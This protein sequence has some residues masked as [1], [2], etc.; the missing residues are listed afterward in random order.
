ML[1]KN[2]YDQKQAGR[3]WHEHLKKG[4]KNIEFE[5]SDF[6][7]C[8]FYRGATIFFVYVDDGVFVSLDDGEINKAITELKKLD[9]KLEDQGDLSDYVGINFRKVEDGRIQMAQPHLIDQILEECGIDER[10]VGKKV[11]ASSTRILQRITKGVLRTI[12]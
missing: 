5:Q 8:V 4:L 9:F 2:L 1:I 7:G 3:V 10:M 6:D 12:G 11:P